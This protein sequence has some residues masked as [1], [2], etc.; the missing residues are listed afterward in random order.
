MPYNYDPTILVDDKIL[1]YTCTSNFTAESTF[2][3]LFGWTDSNN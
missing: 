2:V 3:R 1:R